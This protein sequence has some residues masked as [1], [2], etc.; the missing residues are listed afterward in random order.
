MDDHEIADHLNQTGLT[1]PE[2]K[3]FTYA[4]VR[5]I[6]YKHGISGPYERNRQGFSVTEAASLL[7]FSTGKVYYGIST[8]KIP[9]RKQHSGWPWEVLI[10][11]TNLDSIKALYT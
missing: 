3:K 2:G 11:N 9:A 8:G 7:G 4:G 5:W 6:R 10:D 1:T